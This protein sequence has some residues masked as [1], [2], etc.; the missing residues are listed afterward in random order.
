MRSSRI[1][2]DPSVNRGPLDVIAI[3]LVL[4]ATLLFDGCRDSSSDARLARRPFA[5]PSVVPVTLSEYRFGIG[6]SIPAGR[7]VFTFSNSGREI[8]HPSLVPLDENIPPIDV[9]IKGTER[10]TVDPLASLND[11][12]PGATGTFAVDLKPGQ[13]YAFICYA[14]ASDG[15]VHGAKGMTFEFRAPLA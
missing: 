1:N 12:A 9:Q 13:R 7:V 11:R 14:T 10:R 8:H 4:F 6:G 15:I 2:T 3:A 5:G